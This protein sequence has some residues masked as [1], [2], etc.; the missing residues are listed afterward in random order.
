VKEQQQRFEMLNNIWVVVTL[1]TLPLVFDNASLE[2]ALAIRVTWLAILNLIGF[3]I[4]FGQAQT[5]PRSKILLAW[6]V[7]FGALVISSLFAINKGEAVWAIAQV[8]IAPLSFVLLFNSLHGRVDLIRRTLVALS[9]LLALIGLSQRFDLPLTWIP[10]DLIPGGM[11]TTK[12]LYASYTF[13]LLPFIIYGTLRETRGWKAQSMIAL[14]L[15]VIVIILE[16]ARSVWLASIVAMFALG[17]LAIVRWKELAWRELLRS[18]SW[19]F[20]IAILGVVL[21]L[22]LSAYKPQEHSARKPSDKVSELIH[23]D[24]DTSSTMRLT[25]WKKSLTMSK[26]HLLIGVGGGN[27]KIELPPHYIQDASNQW[28]HP[29]NDFV[30]ALTEAGLFGLLGYTS[31]FAIGLVIAFRCSR[32]RAGQNARLFYSLVFAS[33]AGFAVISFFDFPKDR[34]EHTLL[35]V[36]IL[37]IIEGGA[38]G[39]VEPLAGFGGRPIM[40]VGMLLSALIVFVG[41]TKLISQEH[42]LSAIQLRLGHRWDRE[43]AEDEAAH[44]QWLCSLD[45]VATPIRYYEAEAYFVEGNYKKSVEENQLALIDHPYYLPALNN[46]GS[47]FAKLGNRDSAIAYY[48]RALKISP[49]FEE[50]R[51]NLAVGYYNSGEFQKA[52]EFARTCDTSIANSRGQQ[53]A[54]MIRSKLP[55]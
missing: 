17:L 30:S 3:A 41:A 11:L 26:E 35:F 45:A 12:N 43:L 54:R 49:T 13:L 55:S 39:R 18:A 32:S 51:L 34:I 14:L 33:V 42:Q 47:S 15:N 5:I 31:L 4:Q 9:L 22:Q 29:H 19:P 37:A 27:W 50:T 1:F 38:D 2:P 6:G 7:Y 44:V 20:A 23:Y 52:F 36:L 46:L 16:Q 21:G 8:L 53:I 24:R 48:L 40:L 28:T 10:L 25:V